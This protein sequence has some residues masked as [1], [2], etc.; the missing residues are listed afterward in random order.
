MQYVFMDGIGI[1]PIN[2]NKRPMDHIAHLSILDPYRNI[3]Q[4]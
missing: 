3:F 4:Y 1:E 2:N